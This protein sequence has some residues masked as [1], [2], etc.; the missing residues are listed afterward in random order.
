VTAIERYAFYGCSAL[1][2]VVIPAGVTTIGVCAFQ[3]CSALQS[4]VIPDSVTTIGVCAFQG[5]SALRSVVIP[6][7][8]TTIEG[9][10]F[11]GCYALESVVIPDS[12][13]TIEGSAF[14]GC[15]ALQSVMIPAGVTAI[16][17]GAFLGCSALES[18]VL[19]D[20]V[21]VIGQRAFANC[22]NLRFVLVPEGLETS[23]E[24]LELE[25]S[26]ALLRYDPRISGRP[27]RARIQAVSSLY[28]R[29]IKAG[30]VTEP[31]VKE[32]LKS[33]L[34]SLFFSKKKMLVPALKALKLFSAIKVL[35]K[36]GDV[37]SGRLLHHVS[38]YVTES[39]QRL[40]GSTEQR[41][42]DCPTAYGAL[43]QLTLALGKKRDSLAD[44]FLC[45]AYQFLTPELGFLMQ[46]DVGLEM[47]SVGRSTSTVGGGV[48]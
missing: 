47:G 13:M 20:S 34:L 43:R 28:A 6:A 23:R 44:P 5:C 21:T 30:E 18:V 48:K 42:V 24:H 27:L 46:N 31:F 45:V 7:G 16:G 39:Q 3:V 14:Y 35:S 25:D 1:E 29:V 15:S 36:S 4:V 38:T 19:P 2:S 22:G 12:V 33:Q 11:Y 17:E 9:S 37:I 10:A 40:L 32:R 8:V 26:T 41:T